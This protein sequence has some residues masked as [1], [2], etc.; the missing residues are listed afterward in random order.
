MRVQRPLYLE[1][2]KHKMHNGLVKVIT[3]I[4]RC[5]KSYLLS[6][7]F[8]GYLRGNGVD[9]SHI[10]EIPLDRDEFR[11]LRDPIRLGEHIRSKLVHDGKWNYVFI[12][13][14]QLVRKV[15]PADIDLARIAPEDRDNAYVTFYDILNGIR[16]T[17]HVD[18][19]VTGSNS[20]TLSSDIAT[21]FRDRGQQLRV[22]PLS[23][24]EWLPVSG[25]S[26]KMEA[27]HRYLT[28]GGMPVAA[29][30]DD[31][32]ERAAYLKGLFDEVYL[33]DIR[34]R[35]GVKDDIALSNLI[36]VLSSDIGSLTNPHKIGD[37][38]NTLWKMHPSDHTLKA[39]IGYLE[40]AFLFGHARRFEVKGR[41]YLDS[42]MKYYATDLG[43]RNA[44]L[45]FRDTDLSHPM[46]NAIYNELLRR[47]CNVDVGVVPISARDGNGRQS[48][49]QH[50]IDFVVNRGNDKIYIQ[51][52]LRLDD[53]A[54]ERQETLS[55][56]KT[57]DFFKKVIITD[58]YDEARSD[59][60]GIIHVGVIPFMLDE[61][62]LK[63]L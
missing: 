36:D 45:N 60:D 23:F 12:D 38:M 33:K 18:V 34:E 16:Q 26:D 31:A 5:G 37:T 22:W 55:L 13:E 62:I 14:I 48:I 2:L 8:G 41:R 32:E 9:A 3:G 4:R 43:L 27:F 15:L 50:E 6:V 24:A 17:D 56:R 53:A 30:T 21:N 44:R 46:E 61:T 49:R 39:Y 54:K 51:L 47:G 20:K 11:E 63:R 59:V 57:G 28:W 7:L 1:A 42:P 25:L 58:G 10:I 40:D 52:A 35:H 19:Y 29:L